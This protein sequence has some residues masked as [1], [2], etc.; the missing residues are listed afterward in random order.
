MRLALLLCLALP[1]PVAAQV[2]PILQALRQNAW[3]AAA[4][5]A[6]ADPDPLAG[7]LVAFIRL[8]NPGQASAAEL[9]RFIADHPTWPDQDRLEHRYGEAL[10]DEPD[11]RVTAGLCTARRPAA[12]PALLHCAEA[13]ALAGDA[14][15]A[16]S[17]ARQGWIALQAPQDQERNVLARWG[18][19]LTQADQQARFDR[20]EPADQDAAQRQLLLLAEPARAVDAARLAFRRRDPDALATLAAVPAAQRTDPALLLAEARTLRRAEADDAALALWR[21]ALPAAEAATPQDRRAPFWSERDALARRLL[22][23]GRDADA[24]AVADD[25]SLPPDQVIEA[26]F[27][28]GWIALRRLHDTARARA[29]FTAL[30]AGAHAAITRARALYWLARAQTD[31]AAARATLASAADWPTTY[32]GQLA[33]RTAGQT[34]AAIAI[35]I[36]GLHDPA[37]TQAQADALAG[38]EL[39]RAAAILVSWADPRRAA[40]FL[41]QMA[42][43]A[44]TAGDRTLVARLALRLGLPDVAVHAA[45]LAGRDGMVLAQSGWPMPFQP[46]QGAV[47]ASLALGIMRQESSFDPAAVSAAGA[48]GLMQLM[49]G[50]AAQVARLLHAPAAPLS[51]P[52]INMRLGAAYLAGLLAQFG[53]AQAPA[54]AAYNAGPHRVH[55]WIAANG[56]PAPGDGTVDWIELIPFA[57]TRNYVQRVLENETIYQARLSAGRVPAGQPG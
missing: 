28:A 35:R 45:R 51:D 17:A 34:D 37:T 53:G 43:S 36:A 29:H 6:D 50:T 15:H 48:R 56:D 54:I 21:T 52:A 14:P 1:A 16:A 57:E 8:L 11:E 4:A 41:H 23:T 27:L 13:W 9:Q 49:G 25:A 2:P 20:L 42:Q 19:V 24:Y 33:A 55:E 18:G 12:G 7:K 31:P 47:P 5:L 40:D 46:P 3:R 26:G 22:A 32:Y 44:A 30:A 10:A 39:A 38:T